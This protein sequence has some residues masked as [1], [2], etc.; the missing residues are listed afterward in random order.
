MKKI[1]EHSEE[2]QENVY[3]PFSTPNEK[4]GNFESMEKTEQPSSTLQGFWKTN[5]LL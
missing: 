3:A 5:I 4:T 1:C 2:L